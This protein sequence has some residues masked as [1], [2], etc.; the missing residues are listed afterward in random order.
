[1]KSNLN[2]LLTATCL[3]LIGLFESQAQTSSFSTK[4]N[5]SRYQNQLEELNSFLEGFD[6]GNSGQISVENDFIIIKYPEGQYC[7]FK[8]EDMAAPVMEERWG[9]IN[10][11]CKNESLCVETDWNDDGKDSGV[12]FSEL[13]SIV[14]GDL[15]GLLNSFI[16]AYN[17][18]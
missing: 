16:A 3:L 13:G 4:K 7:K 11:D 17:G 15:L 8:M 12:L 9:Q 6:Q 5:P 10:W 14:L 2:L 1:M 18:K